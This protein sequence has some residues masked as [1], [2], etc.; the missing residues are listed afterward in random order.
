MNGPPKMYLYKR[1]EFRNEINVQQELFLA[2]LVIG[3]GNDHSTCWPKFTS[4]NFR[5]FGIKVQN[6]HYIPT[7]ISFPK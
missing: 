5:L 4:I 3:I 2:Q 7:V 6:L 1:L